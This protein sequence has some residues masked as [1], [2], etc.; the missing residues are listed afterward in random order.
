MPF[1]YFYM[2]MRL[3]VSDVT[4]SDCCLMKP[5]PPLCLSYGLSHSGHR[6][7][8]NSIPNSTTG[9]HAT[10]QKGE[11]NAQLSPKSELCGFNWANNHNKCV[12]DSSYY[13]GG[14]VPS[15]DQYLFISSME[16]LGAEAESDGL[17]GGPRC[18]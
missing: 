5:P 9:T 18:G 6:D 12:H 10:T 3:A 11:D 4:L 8:I 17:E 16:V 7:R 15:L 1:S 14:G 2:A 13:K